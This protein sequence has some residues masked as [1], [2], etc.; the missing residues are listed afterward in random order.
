M[1]INILSVNFW[2]GFRIA[3]PEFKVN[4]AMANRGG[5]PNLKKKCVYQKKF[6]HLNLVLTAVS[7]STVFSVKNSAELQLFCRLAVF[8]TAIAFE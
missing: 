4:I 8:N 5:S 7:N 6:E 3:P 2:F 1:I